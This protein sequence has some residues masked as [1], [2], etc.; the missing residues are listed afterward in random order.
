M[1]R[2]EAIEFYERYIQLKLNHGYK[3]TAMG[4]YCEPIRLNKPMD[5]EVA[6][7]MDFIAQIFIQ[8]NSLHLLENRQLKVLANDE[9]L[10]QRISEILNR[11]N[12]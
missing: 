8:S 9:R 7:E 11:I 12:I 3:A 2:K 5:P 1:T 4:M 6:K 10:G